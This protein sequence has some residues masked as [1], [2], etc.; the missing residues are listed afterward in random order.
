MSTG[1]PNLRHFLALAAIGETGRLSTAAERVYLSQSALTQALRKLEA[2]AGA[3]LFERSGY[4][5]TATDAGQRLVRRAHRAAE[6]LASAERDLRALQPAS[7]PL[8]RL[9]QN[10]TTSQLRT[11]TAVV[12][13]RGYSTAARRLRVAQPTVHRA[14]KELELAVGVELFRRASR[15]VES[16]GAARLLAR[17]AELVLAEMRQGLEEVRELQGD[18]GSRIAVGCLPLA[19]SEFLPQALTNLLA[20]H[21]DAQISILDG[22]YVE[23]LHALRYG[24]IDWLI[25]A[26]RDPPPVADIRQEPLFDEP[27][28]IVVRPGHPLIGNAPPSFEELARLEWIAP[29]QL[30]PTRRFFDEF[31]ERGGVTRS[32]RVIEC[33]SLIATRGLL[34]RSDRAAM[35]SPMQVRED[36][37]AGELAMLVETIPGSD[38]TIGIATREDW[39][40]TM[41][42]AEFAHIIRGLAQGL[43]S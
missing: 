17:Y 4:G 36:V 3:Q 42:Q 6:L 28:A 32:P 15:G 16:T 40:P 35:L 22:P 12:E 26:L 8:P 13:T 30:A 20:R 38:R 10:I 7:A 2:D 19:R 29:R 1:Y 9:Q 18:T 24:Q 21:P 37:A 14:A 27:L 11:L 5:V 43:A 23:Q 33:S 41:V 25:G 39:E 31:F 34:Q